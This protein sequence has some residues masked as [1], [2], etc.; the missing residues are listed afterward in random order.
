MG[1]L[2]QKGWAKFEKRDGDTILIPQ[3]APPSPDEKTLEAIVLAQA[4]KKP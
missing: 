3:N 1:W 2:R 4:R